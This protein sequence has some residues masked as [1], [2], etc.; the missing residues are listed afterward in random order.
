[1]VAIMYIIPHR[2]LDCRRIN[3][4]ENSDFLFDAAVVHLLCLNNVFIATTKKMHAFM[5]FV[6]STGHFLHKKEAFLHRIYVNYFRILLPTTTILFRACPLV[7]FEPY[8]QHSYPNRVVYQS[9]MKNTEKG[10]QTKGDKGRKGIKVEK[11]Q[12]AILLVL[13]Y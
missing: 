6:A 8:W 3:W 7:L 12:P 13:F 11:V 4:D 9:R 5:R 1:M 10:R 2:F